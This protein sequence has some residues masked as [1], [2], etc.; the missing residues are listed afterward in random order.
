MAA[1]PVF[2]MDQKTALSPQWCQ[3]FRG[4]VFFSGIH[5]TICIYALIRYYELHRVVQW[6]LGYV[7]GED[8]CVY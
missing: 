6:E 5:K 2:R 7:K 1:Y 4:T 8:L 3:T